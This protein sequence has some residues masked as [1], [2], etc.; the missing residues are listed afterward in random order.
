MCVTAPSRSVTQYDKQTPSPPT[1]SKHPLNLFETF[2]TLKEKQFPFEN[3]SALDWEKILSLMSPIT[4]INVNT[5][6]YRFTGVGTVE[7]GVGMVGTG[8]GRVVRTG[9]F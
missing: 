4:S 2:S 5:Y 1:K 3:F 9:V 6:K 8:V 7:T